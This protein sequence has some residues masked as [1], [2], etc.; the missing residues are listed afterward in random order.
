MTDML[1]P[2]SPAAA[3]ASLPKNLKTIPKY[4]LADKIPETKADDKVKTTGAQVDP[5]R[6]RSPSCTYLTGW[7]MSHFNSDLSDDKTGTRKRRRSTRGQSELFV[8][9]SIFYLDR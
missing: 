6:F 3:L 9:A 8:S 5:T 2:F 4:T 1:T 7:K